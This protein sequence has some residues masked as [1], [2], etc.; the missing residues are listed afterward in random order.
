M[1]VG[2]QKDRGLRDMGLWYISVVNLVLP[3]PLPE[4]TLLPL[5]LGLSPSKPGFSLGWDR[6]VSGF[7]SGT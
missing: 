3:R 5:G 2:N 4:R 6:L 7:V 1:R